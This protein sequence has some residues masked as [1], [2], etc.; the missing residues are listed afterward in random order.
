MSRLLL[1]ICL[2]AVAGC[3]Q[4]ASNSDAKKEA[5]DAVV[6]PGEAP[7][8]QPPSQPVD[9]EKDGGGDKGKF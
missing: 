2:L 9:P 7:K 4:S 6:A 5:A 3:R 1:L 8:V